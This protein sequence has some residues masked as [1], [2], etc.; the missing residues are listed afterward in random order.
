MDSATLIDA[1]YLS[2]TKMEDSKAGICDNHSRP[3]IMGI[4]GVG[5]GVQT[6]Y[7]QSSFL[8][9]TPETENGR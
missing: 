9:L 7:H 3:F 2:D 8:E 1:E 6:R 5:A 4:M